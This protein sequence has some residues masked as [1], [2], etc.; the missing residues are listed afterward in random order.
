[1]LFLFLLLGRINDGCGWRWVDSLKLA[2]CIRLGYLV[3]HLLT[4]LQKHSAIGVHGFAISP[5][6]PHQC[7]GEMGPNHI[8]EIAAFT[9]LFSGP[10]SQC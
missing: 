3:H 10:L 6:P 8:S 2:R 4:W 5:K 7:P 9:D 1:V